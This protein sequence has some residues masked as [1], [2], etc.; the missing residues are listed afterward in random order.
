MSW[1]RRSGHPHFELCSA[2]SFLP[3]SFLLQ[4]FHALFKLSLQPLLFPLQLVSL[5]FHLQF[6]ST[7]FDLSFFSASFELL[8]QVDL[9]SR[10]RCSRGL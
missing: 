8:A 5:P 3:T 6:V 10:L 2:F 4:L 7:S 1:A 9:P